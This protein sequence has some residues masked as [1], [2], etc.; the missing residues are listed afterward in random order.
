MSEN[1]Q[2]SQS[3]KP[4]LFKFGIG[5]IAGL[6]LLARIGYGQSQVPN[7]QAILQGLI[8]A[9]AVQPIEKD[10]AHK[11]QPG[12]P[13]KLSVVVENKGT[14]ASP[15]AEIYLRYAFAKPLEKEK[16]SVIFQTEK[17]PLPSIEPGKSVALA[18]TTPH[19]WPALADFVR[20]DWS[21]R[22]YQAVAVFGKEEL[23]IGSLA[24]TFSA[25]YYPGIRKEI[26]IQI[27]MESGTAH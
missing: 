19:A 20:D 9:E 17:L 27:P 8:H 4:W 14:Q 26:P 24:V 16:D 5:L 22:E 1:S 13:A 3:S 18:F 15:N 6:L 23:V 7:S 11:V 2:P 12:T 25:Y 21:M 10:A